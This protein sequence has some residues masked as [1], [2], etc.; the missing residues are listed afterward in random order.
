MILKKISRNLIKTPLQP[1][2][3]LSEKRKTSS[4][5]EM[6]LCELAENVSVKNKY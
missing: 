4:K 3:T 2:I 5:E 1:D 6:D